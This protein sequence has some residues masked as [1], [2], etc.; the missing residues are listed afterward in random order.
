METTT[1]AATPST[2]SSQA[3]T[4][5]ATNETTPTT[6]Q[7]VAQERKPQLEKFKLKVDGEEFEEEFDLS[8]REELT[9]RFQLAKAAE[10]RIGQAKTEKQ[11]AMEIIKAYED[12]TILQNHPKARELAEKLLLKQLEDEM[13]DPKDKELLSTK[14]KLA[15]YEKDE[16]DRKKQIEAQAMA[17]KELEVAKGLQNTIIEALEKSG[18]PKTPDLAKRMAYIMKKNLEMGLSLT[19]DDLVSELKSEVLGM[20]KSIVGGSDGEKLISL[21]G[22]DA[23]KKI[24]A[25]DVKK[26][27]AGFNDTNKKTQT[28]KVEAP[29]AKDGKPLS[30][31]EW[32]EQVRARARS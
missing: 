11:K 25:Y 32:K 24:R 15:K 14:E 17:A 8:N 20:I 26:I 13:M 29:K 19:P 12:G 6:N 27:K 18:L 3:P 4:E 30:L 2:E 31:E 23:A 28:D 1:A 21:L 16:E 9:K 5:A 10:K 22:D 7:E